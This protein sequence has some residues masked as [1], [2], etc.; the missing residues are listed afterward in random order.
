MDVGIRERKKRRNRVLA[1]CIPL[2]LCVMVYT[3]LALPG[4]MAVKRAEDNVDNAAGVNPEISTTH[5]YTA[6]EVMDNDRFPDQYVK[7]DDMETVDLLYS[8]VHGAFEDV[9]CLVEAD[10]TD[11]TD[12]MPDGGFG[13]GTAEVAPENVTKD[14]SHGATKGEDQTLTCSDGKVCP[15]YRIVFSSAE[16]KDRVYLLEGRTLTDLTTKVQVVLGDTVYTALTEHLD[17]FLTKE[18]AT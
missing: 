7:K 4:G 1:V 2:C 17:R 12:A 5:L 15:V 8:L 18:E 13:E 14:E 10:K 6:V 11:K 9:T 3:G 16:G